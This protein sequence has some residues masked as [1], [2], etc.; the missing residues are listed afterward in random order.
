M[1]LK[2]QNI[3]GFLLCFMLCRSI[4]NAS[5]IVS[6]I[7]KTVLNSANASFEIYASADSGTQLVGGYG[8]TL[9]LNYLPVSGFTA[10][11]VTPTFV[12]PGPP[13]TKWS[14]LDNTGPTL[15]SNTIT[16]RGGNNPPPIGTNTQPYNVSIGTGQ[17]T[18]TLIGTVSFVRDPHTTYTIS[19][20]L[21]STLVTQ[22]GNF[23][24]FLA[25]SST[26]AGG[27]NFNNTAATVGSTV[28]PFAITA[29]PEPSTMALVGLAVGGFGLKRF[30]SRRKRNAK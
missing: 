20:S 5:I 4:G 18:N 11:Q 21:T 14:G 12:P 17:S 30:R 25:V 24:G 28:N 27:G 2:Y 23:Q 15:T 19:S 22:L 3:L 6:F 26:D 16:F 29:V 1:R 10:T 13:E 8:F 7:D 9:S